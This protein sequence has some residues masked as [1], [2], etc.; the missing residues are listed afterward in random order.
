MAEVSQPGKSA[1]DLEEVIAR[2]EAAWQE[3]RPPTLDDYLPD[4]AAPPLD[5]LIELVHADLEC[6][7]KAGEEA[8][9][10][11]YLERYPALA[12]ERTAVLDLIAAEYRFRQ[13]RRPDTTLEEYGRR[14]PAYRAELSAHVKAAE[15]GPPVNLLDSQKDSGAST[16]PQSGPARPAP[17]WDEGDWPRLP[18]YEVEGVIGRGGMGVVLRA[19]HRVLD[20]L[21][22]LKLPLATQ[23]AGQVDRERFLREARSAARLRHPHICPIYEVGESHGRPYLAMGFIQGQTLRDW[24]A[25][26][27]PSPRQAAEMVALLARAVGYAH[28]QGV[29]HRDIKPANVMVEEP[30]GKPVL[31]DFGLAK[32][33]SEQAVQMTHTGQVMG[34]PAYMAP[35]QAAGQSGRVGPSADVY[36]LGV[37]LYEL[38]CGRLP[39]TGGVGEVLRKV[40][41]ED[42]PAPR[43][44]VPRLHRDLETVCLKAMARDPRRRYASAEELAEDLERWGAGEAIRARREGIAGKLWR[45]VR[46]NPVAAFS[47]LAAVVAA[48]VVVVA[49]SW[50]GEDREQ[51]SR[52]RHLADL[53]SRFEA[54]LK[55]EAWSADHLRAMDALVAELGRNDADQAAAAR[56]RLQQA[57]FQHV[58]GK[59][60]RARLTPEDVT[61]IDGLI[62]LLAGR[63]AGL[64][65]RARELRAQRVRDWETVFDL[66]APYAELPQVFVAGR[67]RVAGGRLVLAGGPAEGRVGVGLPGLTRVPC[68]GNVQLKAEFDPGWES[69][70]EV[71]LLLNVSQGHH[72]TVQAAAFSPD[73]QVVATASADGLVAVWDLGTIQERFILKGHQ[74]PVNA[75]AFSPDGKR[76]ATG[77]DDGRV[78]FWDAAT[79]KE[80]AAPV[81]GEKFPGPV[82]GLAFSGDGGTLA[83]GGGPW[84]GAGVVH[85]W[86]LEQGKRLAA[87]TGHGGV[88][89]GVAF[90]PGSATR[91][92]SAGA[93]ATVRLWDLEAGKPPVVLR[94]PRAGVYGVAFSPDGKVV[95][96]ASPDGLVRLWDVRTGKEQA[97]LQ[98]YAAGVYGVAFSPDGRSLAACYDNACVK[99]WDT[100]T[101]EVRATLGGHG[102]RVVTVAYAPDGQAL[103][104]G[105]WGG[106]AKLWDVTALRERATLGPQSYAFVLSVP[107]DLNAAPGQEPAKGPATLG[108]ARRA[109]IPLRM[110]IS[111]NGILQREQEVSVRAGP[112]R[113]LAVREGDRLLFQ[114]DDLAPVVFRDVWPN[115]PR[116]GVFGVHGPAGLRLVALEART[117]LVPPAASPLER[118]DEL[119]AA[120][121]FDEALEYYR[122]QAHQADASPAGRA[123]RRETLCKA[124]LCLAGLWRLDEAAGLFEEVATEVGQP[125]EPWP[126]L[127]AFQLWHLR[128]RQQRFD[129]TEQVFDAL[130]LRYPRSFAET[131][132]GLV[133]EDLRVQIW[134]AYYQVARVHRL[135]RLHPRLLRHLERGVAVADLFRAPAAYRVTARL[136]LAFAYQM[137]GREEDAR[138]TAREATRE[139][140]DLLLSGI[141]LPDYCWLMRL[142]GRAEQ[143][144]QEIDRR[145]FQAPGV[146]RAD[147]PARLCASLLERARLNASLKDW[148]AAEGDLALFFR[149]AQAKSIPYVYYSGAC[150]VQ[151]FLRERAGDA[152]GAQAAWR[153]GT[154]GAWVKTPPL[155]DPVAADPGA[156]GGFGTF[157][158]LLLAALANELPDAEARQILAQ[159]VGRM[160]GGGE[161]GQVLKLVP[162]PPSVLRTMLQTPRGRE[163]ARQAA[164]R[165]LPTP[166]LF[167]RLAL[168]T[169]AEWV[170]QTG[171]PGP[172]SAE[173]D[174]LLWNFIGDS[175]SAFCAGDIGLAHLVALGY[176]WKGNAGAWGWKGIA[177]KLGPKLRGPAAYLIGQRYLQVLKKPK[178][179]RAFFETARREAPADSALRRLAQAEIERLKKS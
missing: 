82:R 91:L 92:A 161:P 102:N 153:R 68:R 52:Q 66:H 149:V 33:L 122:R 37:V 115:R 62:A 98:G 160:G 113:L 73:G 96:G 72:G 74:G 157:H 168:L 123:F 108:A 28:S 70:A 77:G 135:V 69:A 159:L 95:A 63:D 152:T 162:L 175:Y 169:A 83:V 130:T 105:G 78:L 154:F 101:H 80:A 39:F 58:E 44:L 84:G 173:Q 10:E 21:V 177:D 179:A 29:V 178:E 17:A 167:R 8:R 35:E 5:L 140:A 143:A 134:Q 32:E 126:L 51:A 103:V 19:R 2:F 136:R 131:I 31:M 171:L 141:D 104:S 49:L 45:K 60:A 107:R 7:L 47:I 114:A 40:Q 109:R 26:R 110:Q 75:V 20:R 93:D 163:Y 13:R 46:R 9:V 14:F 23:L 54:G 34:T 111:R 25:A 15:S 172:L 42:P 120:R 11:T 90:A 144:R 12:G 156:R 164:F 148:A 116:A 176:A 129:D 6:R 125:G 147:E 18:Q 85:V 146:L 151:G 16:V 106:T 89:W 97:A 158:H 139:S 166:E 137:L 81:L 4:P 59:L 3:G 65:R 112:L 64:G 48:G 71:G 61:R 133:S 145:L 27:R 150:L 117:Q 87:L 127:A 138:R 22:A 124:G 86:D 30:T 165:E 128:L 118:G 1:V 50:A 67:A 121:Q 174:E 36:A 170:H 99:I 119:F 132:A 56:R 79:G 57:F 41:T 55:A 76:L 94:G 155:P 88:V 142:A 100:A 24:A 38:L 53:S 43:K